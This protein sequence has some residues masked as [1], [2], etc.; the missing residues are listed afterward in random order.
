MKTIQIKQVKDP[1]RCA[2]YSFP[3][4][5]G[6]GKC[7]DP[8]EEPGSCKECPHS[9]SVRDPY[10]TGD[11]WYSEPECNYGSPCPWGK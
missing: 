5:A 8:G 2:A 4:R 9:V 6:S 11:R 7:N 1:C 10:G 3:H